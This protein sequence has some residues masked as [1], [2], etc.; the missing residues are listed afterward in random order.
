MA[1]IKP[2]LDTNANLDDSETDQRVSYFVETIGFNNGFASFYLGCKLFAMMTPVL[3]FYF[4]CAVPGYLFKTYGLDVITAFTSDSWPSPMDALFPKMAKCEWIKYGYGGDMEVRS[5]QCQLPMNN[6]TQWSFFVF[7]WWL[8]F[9]FIINLV[10]FLRLITLT[11]P[12]CRQIKYK[13]FVQVACR[14]DVEKARTY[15]VQLKGIVETK[16]LKRKDVISVN[17]QFGDLVLISFLKRNLA[18]WQFREF[19]RKLVVTKNEVLQ[20]R[21][22]PAHCNLD[23]EID[24]KPSQMQQNIQMGFILPPGITSYQPPSAPAPP[25]ETTSE[26]VSSTD[27]ERKH[28]TCNSETGLITPSEM[29]DL[30]IA[31]GAPVKIERERERS[32]N[33]KGSSSNSGNP[34]SK[35]SSSQCK[36]PPPKKARPPPP[37]FAL[38]RY[39]KKNKDIDDEEWD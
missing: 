1:K 33:K 28:S 25:S 21:A 30:S 27:D 8:L 7:W 2:L 10:S 11:L 18:D 38:P 32:P 37:G 3:E 12:H 17:M 6:L 35:T 31:I 20:L 15:T 19:I 4:L 34:S 16:K 23:P 9:V 39:Q 5:A 24:E 13:N 22:V 26:N 29:N 14:E 36:K